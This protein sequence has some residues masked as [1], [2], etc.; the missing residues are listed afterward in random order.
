MKKLALIPFFAVLFVLFNGC[1]SEPPPPP[2]PLV[3]RNPEVRKY[4]DVLSELVNEYCTLMQETIAKAKEME[5]KQDAG[6]IGILDGIDMLSGAATSLI[7]IKNLADE[8]ESME[9]QKADFEKN[10]SAE[11]FK[12]FLSLSGKSLACFYELAA[13]AEELDNP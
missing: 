2:L 10:L 11:D 9:A 5:E 13:Q 1:K 4:I 7:K 8:I 6:E 3:E 12:E